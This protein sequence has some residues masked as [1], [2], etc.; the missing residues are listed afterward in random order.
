MFCIDPGNEMSGYLL[1]LDGRFPDKG[2]RTNCEIM[3]IMRQSLCDQNE[4]HVVIERIESQGMA[5]GDSVFRTCE[6]VGRFSQV[7]ED[8]GA[9][10]DYVYRRDEKL[11]LCE[12][13]RAKDK[14]IRRALIDRYAT[15]DMESGRGTKKHPDVLY[16]FSADA[17]SALAVYTTWKDERDGVY[18]S[19]RNKRE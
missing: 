6:W 17:W 3:Q 4:T 18:H 14:N 15:F 2:K 11:C 13:S 12:N 1:V 19:V 8:M 10:V 7:A 16:G 9:C 5:V